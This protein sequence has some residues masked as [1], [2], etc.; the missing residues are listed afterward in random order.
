MKYVS[1]FISLDD[2]YC[3]IDCFILMVFGEGES[4]GKILKD[5]CRMLELQ[6]LFLTNYSELESLRVLNRN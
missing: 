5:D 3:E 4:W 6:D 2:H 1:S